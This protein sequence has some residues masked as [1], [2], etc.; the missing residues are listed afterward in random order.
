MADSAG[1]RQGEKADKVFSS[2]YPL[3]YASISPTS[4]GYEGVAAI[5]AALADAHLGIRDRT[6]LDIGCG[7]GTV[8]L[9]AAA[10]APEKIYAVDNS[11]GMI[12]LLKETLVGNK[13]LSDWMSGKEGAREVLGEYF[14][15]TLRHLLAMRNAFRGGIFLRRGGKLEA[16]KADGLRVDSLGLDPIDL[17]VGSNYLHWPV[18]QSLAEMKKKSPEIPT[19]ILLKSACS[20]ALRPLAK[21]MKPGGIMVLM[22]GEDFI[23]FDDAPEEEQD[24]CG[25]VAVEHPVFLKF[26]SIFAGLLK[27]RY[28]IENDVPKRSNLFPRST[29]KSI[30][31]ENG[32]KLERF[33][34]LENVCVNYLDSIFAGFPMMMGS[35]DIPFEEKMKLGREVRSRLLASVTPEELAVPNRS[36]WFFQVLERV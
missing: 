28:G 6:V 24:F 21:V 4:G 1:S 25:N 5:I 29:L 32:F 35:V 30:F 26:H 23:T 31:A 12:E 17:I 7:F 15:P 27:K 20:V 18:I 14:E 33:H 2:I 8:A 36:Q 3:L 16:I 22:E 19:E 10:Y 11:G 34:H 9:A 13:N